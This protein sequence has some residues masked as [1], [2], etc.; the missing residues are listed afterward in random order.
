MNLFLLK[1]IFIL[2]YKIR[3]LYI[4]SLIIILNY[5]YTKSIIEKKYQQKI[6]EIKEIHK[7]KN[8]ELMKKEEKLVEKKTI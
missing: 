8:R 5:T 7:S 2:N 4:K 6:L 1:N 3:H